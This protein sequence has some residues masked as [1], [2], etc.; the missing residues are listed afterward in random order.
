MPSDERPR[1][2]GPLPPPTLREATPADVPVLAVLGAQVFI[3]TYATDGIRPMLAR[4]VQQAFDPAAVAALLA[5]PRA[6]L[7][8]AERA[9][10]L[11]GFVQFAAGVPQAQVAAAGGA[12]PGEIER[13]YVLP[14]FQRQ[15][16]G[17]ALLAAAAHALRGQGCRTLWL[18][19]WV[20]N[21]HALAWY[22]AQGWRDIG[23]TPYRFED[24]EFENRVLVRD[25]GAAA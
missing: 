16:L 20:G 15:G 21:T 11:L 13:L 1:G 6:G 7:I 23:A 12:E 3:A 25:A 8:V 18:T 5:R 24:E 10:H 2:Q 4:E 19:A 22:R 14:R 17:V 9:G